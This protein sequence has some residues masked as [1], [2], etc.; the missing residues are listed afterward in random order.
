MANSAGRFTGWLFFEPKGCRC[1]RALADGSERCRSSGSQARAGTSVSVISVIVL[2]A[3][4]GADR[5]FAEVNRE[6]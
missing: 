4:E 5:F 2:V 1:G 6:G 3:W